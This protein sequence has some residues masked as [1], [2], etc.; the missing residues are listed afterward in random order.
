MYVLRV[1]C[2]GFLAQQ[3]QLI[4]GHN[5]DRAIYLGTRLSGYRKAYLLSKLKLS[6][7]HEAFLYKKGTGNEIIRVMKAE[8]KGEG[9]KEEMNKSKIKKKVT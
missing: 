9:S 1:T 3:D 8:M 7:F 6:V 4:Y 5:V 2:W